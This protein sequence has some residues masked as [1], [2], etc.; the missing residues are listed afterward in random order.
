MGNISVVSFQSFDYIRADVAARALLDVLDTEV[1]YVHLMHP[2]PIPAA[3]LLKLIAAKLD[4]P[5][6]HID[7]WLEIMVH[8]HD[9]AVEAAN[10]EYPNDEKARWE[11]M[12]GHYRLN[13]ASRIIPFFSKL[14]ETSQG[15]GLEAGVSTSV[16][17]LFETKVSV[18]ES[19]TLQGLMRE[20]LGLEDIE[21]WFV[22]WRE[23][24]LFVGLKK[25]KVD[26]RL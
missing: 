4:L 2:N 21:R 26:A 5:A 23:A 18:R 15:K 11:A 10:R 1:P 24:G 8:E 19:R 25:E 7:K 22:K 9:A 13:P 3:D 12:R 14:S 6:V 16:T 17:T 20:Q